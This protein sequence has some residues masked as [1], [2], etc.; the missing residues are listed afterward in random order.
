MGQFVV[1]A[2]AEM[3][4]FALLRVNRL[5]ISEQDDAVSRFSA[6][7]SGALT[8]SMMELDM[9]ESQQVV[10]ELSHK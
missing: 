1:L 2:Q 8:G 6:V 9:V 7:E 5:R 10:V 3:K 4:I